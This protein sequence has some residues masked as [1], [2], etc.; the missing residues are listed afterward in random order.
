[1]PAWWQGSKKPRPIC[2]TPRILYVASP[3]PAQ[4]AAG[5][6]SRPGAGAIAA[7]SRQ[8]RWHTPDPRGGKDP[9]AAAGSAG[10][11]GPPAPADQPVTASSRSARHCPPAAL[12]LPVRPPATQRLFRPAARWDPS[13]RQGEGADSHRRSHPHG[14]PTA[15]CIRRAGG[16]QRL[17][18]GRPS[19]ILGPT[20]RGAG[21]PHRNR[22]GTPSCSPKGGASSS[23]RPDTPR[24]ANSSPAGTRI[25]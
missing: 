14:A 18:K 2:R 6:P 12:P 15:D 10:R 11:R 7:D 1:M 13:P 4:Q 17:P 24:L 22:R 9:T 21:R 3:S 16:Q 25:D 20:S 8:P 19:P 5:Q 23:E